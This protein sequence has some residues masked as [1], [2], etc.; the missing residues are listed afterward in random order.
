MKSKLVLILGMILVTSSAFASQYRV[1]GWQSCLQYVNCPP[2]GYLPQRVGCSTEGVF[3]AHSCEEAWHYLKTN[4]DC[5]SEM[6]LATSQHFG[7][8]TCQ[9]VSQ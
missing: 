4:Q 3:E 6:P 9:L 5:C 7:T 8:N 2:H 1:T